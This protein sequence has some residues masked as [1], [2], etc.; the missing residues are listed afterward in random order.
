[1]DPFPTLAPLPP[2][3]N[4]AELVHAI[5]NS[6]D[7]TVVSG[8]KIGGRKNEKHTRE[9]SLPLR[10]YGYMAKRLVFQVSFPFFSAYESAG[11]HL[12]AKHKAQCRPRFK[13][14]AETTL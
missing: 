3:I 7:H 11:E 2:D 8:T 14:R 4:H 1:M 10:G 12:V 13:A 6:R 9:K 5:R